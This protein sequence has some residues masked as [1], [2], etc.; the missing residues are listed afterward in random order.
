MTIISDINPWLCEG[1][2]LIYVPS[3][4]VIESDNEWDNCLFFM[5]P[6]LLFSIK[7]IHVCALSVLR[8][9]DMI[10]VIFIQL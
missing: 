6:A 7:N 1:L 10:F 2:K 3:S 5:M 8:Y 4:L 9:N